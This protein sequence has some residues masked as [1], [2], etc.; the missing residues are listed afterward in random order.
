MENQNGDKQRIKDDRPIM[1]KYVLLSE[2][3][4]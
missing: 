1:G 3:L 4:H 2:S